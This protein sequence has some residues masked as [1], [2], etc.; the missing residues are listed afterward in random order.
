MAQGRLRIR[1]N[2]ASRLKKRTFPVGDI[3]DYRAFISL[4]NNNYITPFYGALLTVGYRQY[5]G[6]NN[7]STGCDGDSG[8]PFFVTIN[9]RRVQAG[10]F[11]FTSNNSLAC[12]DR[13]ITDNYLGYVDTS[14]SFVL[15]FIKRH[16]PRAHVINGNIS[17]SPII[18]MLLL[19]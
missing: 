8:S 15:S 4:I 3:Y 5:V 7:P 16:A 14:E 18:N 10:V 1:I 12:F 17:I 19:E 2:K 9:G 11:S 13:N 6:S